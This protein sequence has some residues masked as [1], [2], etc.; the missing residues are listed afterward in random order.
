MAETGLG[1]NQR[2]AWME[3]GSCC[4]GFSLLIGSPRLFLKAL[5]KPKQTFPL[6]KHAVAFAH[7]IVRIPPMTFSGFKQYTWRALQL[8]LR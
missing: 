7:S 1:G 6:E 4:G 8:H 2:V 5:A 3:S